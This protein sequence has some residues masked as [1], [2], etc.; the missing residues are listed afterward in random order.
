MDK[1]QIVAIALAVLPHIVA[2]IPGLAKGEGIISAVLNFLAGNY[3][4]AKNGK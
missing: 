2:L 3:G 4:A 1:G